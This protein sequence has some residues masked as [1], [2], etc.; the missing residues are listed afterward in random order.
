MDFCQTTSLA[1]IQ[2][3][4]NLV[5]GIIYHVGLDR[6]KIYLRGLFIVVPHTKADGFHRYISGLGDACPGMSCDIHGQGHAYSCQF[7]Y[8]LQIF[9][10]Q[11]HLVLVLLPLRA[12][13]PC[14]DRK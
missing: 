13:L 6:R 10:Y 5:V 14:D 4:Q 2:K 9:V 8:F 12:V 11:Q 7:R 1:L 3:I